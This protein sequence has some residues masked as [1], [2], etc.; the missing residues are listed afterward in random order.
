MTRPSDEELRAAL[1]KLPIPEP[2][3]DAKKT[4]LRQ[5]LQ[6]FDAE[7][8]K[9]FQGS[10]ETLRPIT[11]TERFFKLMGDWNMNASTL[12]AAGVAAVSAA[13]VLGVTYNVVLP[14]QPLDAP[15]VTPQL[16]MDSAKIR[17]MRA[18][19]AAR[20]EAARLQAERAAT[21]PAPIPAP[22]P[23]PQLDYDVSD[24]GGGGSAYSGGWG[25]SQP[26]GGAV[27]AKRPDMPTPVPG[28]AQESAVIEMA[29]KR[30][31][32]YS[33]VRRGPPIASL[34]GAGRPMGLAME[35]PG[36]IAHSA[37]PTQAYQMMA[38]PES[39]LEAPAQERDQF[40]EIDPNT[41]KVVAEDP[42][43]TFSV[44]VDTASYSFVRRALNGGRLPPPDAVRV[45]E[46]INYFNYAYELPDDRKTPFKPTVALYPT[47]WNEETQLLHIGIK[48]F[49]L[50]DGAKPK[51]NLVF[52][53]DVSGSMSARDK[54]PLLKNSLSLLVDQLE[55]DDT[56]GI[57]V[58]A[59]A[60]GTVLDPTPVKEKHKIKAALEKLQ[61]GG[62][63][64]GGEGIRAAYALA[65]GV[66]D[67][68]AVNRVILATD[69]D[70][71]VG[72]TDRRALKGMI[73]RKRKSGIFLSILGFGRG[74]Y[75]DA[76]MQELAQNGNGTAAYIDTLNEARKVLVEE[77]SS[78]L[79]P[80]AK[81]VKIQVEFNPAKVAEYRLIGYETRKLARADFKNDKVDAGDI[82]AG[83][84]VTAL[85][86]ITPVGS[87]R[88]VEP[89][90]YGDKA[91]APTQG[92]DEYAFLK[93]RFK[94]PDE[95]SS[96][97][98]TRAIT[99]KDA[100]ASIGAAPNDM[101]FAAAVAAF[102]QKLTGGTHTGNFDFSGIIKLANGA[103]GADPY[104][105]RAEFVSLVRLAQSLDR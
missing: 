67:K 18:D 83:H 10:E 58:Y 84:T 48:G 78:A 3:D 17:E 45:E 88:Q 98:M 65:E 30:A 96:R 13:I 73:E 22:S 105:Y 43:S 63:T 79:F 56:V 39:R 9:K 36:V 31:Q 93:L 38:A 54:L 50:P 15:I 103:K 6:A 94:R 51:S 60:A 35:T 81:D 61:A 69:G 53:I 20:V 40:T 75:N 23:Q 92:G 59:G 12:K 87:A 33:T 29:K 68:Q 47:P 104:G 57:V 14:L 89:L 90:R 52:L 4:A 76:L 42:V 21:E 34:G 99:A 74:N 49:D 102:G 85:Y 70:F 80:I 27:M 95:E 1:N 5:G 62:S 11:M 7:I 64:A 24:G 91:Q 25:A 101:R 82:G 66:Y 16:A 97:L 2:G 19:Q 32:R 72:Q 86:E 44:D 26:G 46:M 55:P 71:N 28:V 100:H 8:E 77:A 41:V 37:P